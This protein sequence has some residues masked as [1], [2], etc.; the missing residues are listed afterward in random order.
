MKDHP[1]DQGDLKRMRKLYLASCCLFAV[2][3]LFAADATEASLRT[4]MKSI[5]PAHGALGKKIAA[6]DATA[7]ADAKMLVTW[8]NT[9]GKFW[10]AKKWDDAIAFNKTAVAS[11]KAIA[12]SAMAGKWD[13]ASKSHQAASATCKGCHSAH[14]GPKGTD[15]V[16]P[17]K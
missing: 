10:K 13:E 11:Y 2:G 7:A 17:I 16:Y 9:S 14:R 5:Q 4:S 12:K 15:G 3:A 6:K 1:K 8:F